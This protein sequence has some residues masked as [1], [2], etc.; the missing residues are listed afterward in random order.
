MNRG[1][2]SLAPWQLLKCPSENPSQVSADDNRSYRPLSIPH[3]PSACV[4]A[5]IDHCLEHKKS[6]G[7]EWGLVPVPL[8]LQ[9]DCM[10]DTPM[11]SI[12][13]LDVVKYTSYREIKVLVRCA[14][15]TDLVC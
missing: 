8:K 13:T 11:G 14:K 5:I 15:W 3:E 12:V 6:A 1:K 10:V 4:R 2:E 7:H 9:D